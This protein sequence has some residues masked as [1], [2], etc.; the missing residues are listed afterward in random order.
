[1]WCFRTILLITFFALT[2]TGT[3]WC[4]DSLIQQDARELKQRENFKTL[5]SQ[6]SDDVKS[7]YHGRLGSHSIYIHAFGSFVSG[8]GPHGRISLNYFG[9]MVT[10]YSGNKRVR[11][12]N[13]D[14]WVTGDGP[15]GRVNLMTTGRSI[16]G[17]VGDA[18]VSVFVSGTM[19]SGTFGGEHFFLSGFDRF[20]PAGLAALLGAL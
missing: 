20:D 14:G 16:F 19:A 6:A 18:S 1:M 15:R 4:Q 17:R 12:H 7:T 3:G 9:S 13:L 11:L 5:W 2:L 8:R 10:G